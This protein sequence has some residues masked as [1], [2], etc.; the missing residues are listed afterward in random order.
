M[1]SERPIVLVVL[2]PASVHDAATRER[3]ERRARASS[4]V[5]HP[6][7][8]SPI[9]S[10]ETL[11]GLLWLVYERPT[12]Q[13]LDRCLAGLPAG[14]LPWAHARPLLLVLVRGLAAAHGRGVVHGSVS[15]ASC[16]VHGIGLDAP[17]LRLLDWGT[18]TNPAADE[19]NLSYS[20]T[21]T[22]GGDPTFMAPE[23][24]GG[25]FGDERADEYL[26][27]LV[28]YFMLVGRPPFQAANA[29][30]L[31]TMHLQSPMPSMRDAGADVPEAAES[32]V[33]A[34]LAKEPQQRPA[35]MALVEQGL[36]AIDELGRLQAV[37]TEE[38]A[39]P[40]GRRGRAKAQAAARD[41]AARRSSESEGGPARGL[42]RRLPGQE[43]VDPR[44]VIPPLVSAGASAPVI[45]T[46]PPT[47]FVGPATELAGASVIPMGSLPS[48]SASPPA[49]VPP[50]QALPAS[51]PVP[52]IPTRAAVP[53]TLEQTLAFSSLERISALAVPASEAPE[54]TVLLTNLEPGPRLG[55]T[56]DAT[57]KL[58]FAAPASDATLML[59]GAELAGGGAAQP[60]TMVLGQS[61][62]SNEKD[63]AA[64]PNA[65]MVAQSPGFEPSYAPTAVLSGA[66]SSGRGV[67]AEV[68]PRGGGTTV[69][70]MG[71]LGFEPRDPAVAQRVMQAAP[72][73]PV[74]P[75]P[76]VPPPSVSSG[77]ERPGSGTVQRP[78]PS[79]M[80]SWVVILVLVAVA[81]V[82]V[83]LALAG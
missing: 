81:G 48:S 49:F 7:I 22:L 53:E 3:F 41:E 17:S 76:Y 27:G 43:I 70:G 72:P 19:P 50:V 71:A 56:P 28:A 4:R 23:T 45:P 25:L 2:R 36:L 21:T 75:A 26:V 57:L 82:A 64:T 11:D 80:G 58:G 78:A 9:D 60:S 32:W 77:A 69:L 40:R 68:T 44:A 37:R 38:S 30:Q 16:W 79:R 34:L 35:S 74:A 20:R 1:D 47:A 54:G 83:G 42:G 46:R 15:P 12:G 52:E 65:T 61:G 33:G 73:A 51:P 14:R 24:A 39:E 66:A 63:M 10:G 62:G 5:R 31:V 6:A 59:S 13:P 67:R 8:G 55:P 29:F 18:N